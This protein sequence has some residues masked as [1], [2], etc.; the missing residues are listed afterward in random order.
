MYNR[1]MNLSIGGALRIDA[2]SG[3]A[4]IGAG[5]KTTALFQSARNFLSPVIVTATS[6]LGSWQ[7]ELADH[8]IMAKTRAALES[9]EHGLNGVLL[10]TGGVEGDRTIPISDDLL[11]WLNEF[12]GD[13]NIPLLIEADGSRQK[14]LKAWAE[15]EPPIPPF[16]KQV[17]HVAGLTALGRALNSDSVHR[18]DIFS[19]IS[20]IEVGET[21]TPE[22]VIN[23]MTHPAGG[24][25]NIPQEARKVAV[26][27]QADTLERQSSA[28]RMVQHLLLT[29]D[30]V[31]ISSL[32]N[33]KI[34]AVHE[35]IAGI[36][37]AAGDS[38]RYGQ[39]KQLLDWRGEPFVRAVAR[40]A[41]EAGLSPV[42]IVT[43]ANV[44]QV[45]S[46]VQG[47]NV[48][49]A[50]NPDWK[51]GQGSSIR[52][53][54][55]AARTSHLGGAIFLLAD[56]PQVT[57]S[58]LRA[59]VEIHAEGMDPIIAPMVM[60][61][62]ANPVLF[63]RATFRDLE[64]I[65]GDVGGRAIFHKHRVVYLPWHDD[66]LLLDVDTPEMYQRLISDHTL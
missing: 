51:S 54:I 38:S 11:A 32:K 22:A 10:V 56:Q 61:R 21:I 30:S 25:K 36:V 49:L 53:G 59:L 52:E 3:V 42:V 7:V 1:K 43:G 55:L 19:K 60:D 26:L 41:L 66:R 34:Y 24:L 15:H 13:H 64:S 46:A 33:S 23:A 29:Y 62:R 14:P 9:L 40:T 58:I 63:D 28:N 2:S 50:R 6:H 47:L 45:E 4:F 20:G 35:P 44:D 39:A 5:G 18:A 8:H 37:L 27:N 31:I 57:T 17:V 16:V 65:Q 48:H 12:C